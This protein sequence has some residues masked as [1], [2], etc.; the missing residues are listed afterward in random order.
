MLQVKLPSQRCGVAE[1]P[2]LKKHNSLL[3]A[4][5]GNGTT[6]SGRCCGTGTRLPRPLGTK[7]VYLLEEEDDL[8]GEELRTSFNIYFIVVIKL[9]FDF[10]L[11]WFA[12][13]EA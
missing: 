13:R 10:E 11:F 1:Y 3:S 9:A 6:L 2:K 8:R 4:L 7:D 12:W 5:L